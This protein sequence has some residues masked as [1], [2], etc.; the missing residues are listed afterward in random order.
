MIRVMTGGGT[1]RAV[2]VTILTTESALEKLSFVLVYY[3]PFCLNTGLHPSN[4]NHSLYE[5]HYHHD[6]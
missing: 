6:T 2:R 5:L 3:I 1:G 4:K